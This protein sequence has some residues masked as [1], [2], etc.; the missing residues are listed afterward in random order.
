MRTHIIFKSMKE[1]YYKGNKIIER[2]GCFYAYVIIDGDIQEFESHSLA[3]AQ[4]II[5]KTENQ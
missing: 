4:S 3:G 1:Y 2:D 5:D